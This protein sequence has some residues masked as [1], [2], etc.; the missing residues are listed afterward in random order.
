MDWMCVCVCIMYVHIF[1]IDECVCVLSETHLCNF[2]SFQQMVCQGI[3][4]TMMPEL[5]DHT[6]FK[7]PNVNFISKI[8]DQSYNLLSILT[9]HLSNTV[10]QKLSKQMTL[11]T[12]RHPFRGYITC[13]W[14]HAKRQKQDSTP[15]LSD[16]K[17]LSL[18]KHLS[19]T[20]VLLFQ[21]R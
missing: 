18:S 21:Y 20:M 17:N 9:Y 4:S 5:E 1:C 3:L 2:I 14:S 8:H 15:D 6:I 10:F 7:M 19:L 13:A 12:K 11:Q 16:I